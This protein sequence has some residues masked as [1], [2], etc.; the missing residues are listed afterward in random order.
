MICSFPP[1]LNKQTELLVLGTMPGATSLQQQEYYAYKQ[2]HFWKIMFTLLHEL[3][4]PALFEQK[5]QLLLRN[6]IGLWD[7]L[8]HCEREGSLDT[9]IR[10]HQEND[11]ESL[12]SEYPLI[13]TLVF[14]G[15]QSHKFFLRKFG[16]LQ[17]I[18]YFVMP[19][20]SPANTMSFEKKLSAWSAVIKQLTD[21][22]PGKCAGGASDA[23]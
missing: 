10:N 12:L 21:N 19:S 18:R 8:Q 6:K 2:N 11:F 20:T 1:I 14:N 3:P 23:R 7:V 16:Q 17:G 5:A 22:V 15:Q 4:V 9:N 13:K